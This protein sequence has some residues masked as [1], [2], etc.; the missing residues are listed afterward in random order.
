VSHEETRNWLADWQRRFGDA[1]M[2]PLDRDSG[3]LAATPERYDRDLLA[4][5][6]ASPTHDAPARLAVYQRQ[7]WFRLFGVLQHEYRLTAALVGA[8]AMNGLAAEFLL[9]HP[10]RVADLRHAADGFT[11]HLEATLPP[12]GVVPGPRQPKVP[13]ALVVE[14]ARVD[15]AFRTVLAAPEAPRYRPSAAEAEPLARSRLVPS[16]SWVIVE[17]TRAMCAQHRLLGDVAP[18]RPVAPPPRHPRPQALAIAR[19][20]EALRVLPLEPLQARLYRLVSLHALDDALARLEAEVA[21]LARP[22]LVSRT[23]VW[24]A[25]SVDLGFWR[26]RE[27]VAA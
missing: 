27:E 23:Q 16:G 15:A 14:G 1:L 22:A 17:E 13:R 4:G 2:T 6:V 25:A 26:G 21:D 9:A 8:W 20:D 12:G 24:L 18:A 10:P 7:Y 19:V 11:A 5:L 3:T